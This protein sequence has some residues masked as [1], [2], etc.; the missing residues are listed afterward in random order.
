VQQYFDA[1]TIAELKAA[2][3]DNS[4]R[5][6]RA[7]AKVGKDLTGHQV[8]KGRGGDVIKS[9]EQWQND[10]TEFRSKNMAALG[11]ASHPDHKQKVA[12]LEAMYKRMYP[13]QVA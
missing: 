4:P 1:D 3:M 7:L 6:I 8:L 9:M 11:D 13:E 5:L 12:E 2:G 10:A